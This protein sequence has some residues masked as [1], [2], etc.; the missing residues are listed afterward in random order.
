LHR[1]LLAQRLDRLERLAR[2]IVAGGSLGSTAGNEQED[3][4][5]T[6]QDLQRQTRQR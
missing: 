1:E 6:A 3:W 5:Q 2:G 4:Q